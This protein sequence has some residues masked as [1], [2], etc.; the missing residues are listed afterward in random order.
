MNPS[1]QKQRKS[2]SDSYKKESTKQVK[3]AIGPTERAPESKQKPQQKPL[4]EIPKV[5][6]ITKPSRSYRW[7]GK[8][9]SGK[10]PKC[11]DTR[12]CKQ[13]DETKQRSAA[14]ELVCMAGGHPDEVWDIPDHVSESEKESERDS[15]EEILVTTSESESENCGGSG[16]GADWEMEVDETA[17]NQDSMSLYEFK[18]NEARPMDDPPTPLRPGSR[19]EEIDYNS[20][21]DYQYGDLYKRHE[22]EANAYVM[23]EDP[24]EVVHPGARPKV[25]QVRLVRS[26]EGAD[27]EDSEDEDGSEGPKRPEKRPGIRYNRYN[28]E[29]RDLT[30]MRNASQLTE[31][32][33]KNFMV[34]LDYE[35]MN[36]VINGV[37]YHTME[38]SQSVRPSDRYVNDPKEDH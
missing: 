38:K 14:H 2:G 28:S 26:K 33:Y 21:D 10:G 15:E 17:V 23:P 36:D 4:P 31:R 11:F 16:P 29:D 9:G 22:G 1:G 18:D 5:N 8:K 7:C 27:S 37:A 30:V 32:Q 3:K 13:R 19:K 6:R 24:N 35:K 12:C 25:R 34:N 20:E